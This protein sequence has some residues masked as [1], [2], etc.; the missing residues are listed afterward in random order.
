MRYKK[1]FILILISILSA[2]SQPDKFFF[3]NLTISV[4]DSLYSMDSSYVGE[5]IEM[6]EKSKINYTISGISYNDQGVCTRLKIPHTF[7]RDEVVK[8]CA[9]YFY[10][11]DNDNDRK[12]EYLEIFPFFVPT[13]QRPWIKVRYFEP[14]ALHIGINHWETIPIPAHPTHIEAEIYNQ[15]IDLS[16]NQS[17][18]FDTADIKIFKEVAKSNDL[19]IS[20]VEEIYKKVLLWQKSQ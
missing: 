3:Q 19:D 1:D 17:G 2:Y 9:L 10:L 5:I 11:L 8:Q 18:V 15:V 13:N 20:I 16:F 12:R 14:G 4:N 7:T 6:A